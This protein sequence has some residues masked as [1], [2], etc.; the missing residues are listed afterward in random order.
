MVSN[1]VESLFIKV[2][3]AGS[4]LSNSTLGLLTL[5]EREEFSL[6]FFSANNP[7]GI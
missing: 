7:A 6:A 1:G 4:C 2:K 3:M 5:G